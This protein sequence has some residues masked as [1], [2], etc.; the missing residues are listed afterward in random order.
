MAQLHFI[1]DTF[2][3]GT[4]V[5]RAEHAALFCLNDCVNNIRF[6]RRDGQADASENSLRQPRVAS[7]IGPVRTSVSRLVNAAAWTAARKPPR[8]ADRLP[9]RSVHQ[10]RI[11][12]IHHQTDRP[13]VVVHEQNFLPRSAAIR[14]LENAAVRIGSE[15]MPHGSNVHSVGIPGI[16]EDCA[17]RVRIAQAG[18]LP[19]LA[20][21]GGF[22]NAV[23][24][25]NGVADVRFAGADV[26]NLWIGWRHRYRADAGAGPRQL[27]ISDVF[28]FGTVGAL[29]NAA[30]HCTGVKE[31]VV[32]RNTGHGDH[33]PA[34]VRANTPPFELAHQCLC[35][36]GFCTF[37]SCE[38]EKQRAYTENR[39]RA[40]IHSKDT[41]HNSIL[42]ANFF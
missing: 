41:S 22:V 23:A 15:H 25:N 31:I 36:N 4:G 40:N 27:A 28:P 10:T 20:G 9:R 42:L 34:D 2:P 37:G 7:D 13:G 19:R 32:S 16:D 35:S 17:G 8:H 26:K 29:P 21:I 5:L 1:V 3:R 33:S 18:I 30:A 24:R 11:T 39:K 14:G 6:A 38:R 12:R